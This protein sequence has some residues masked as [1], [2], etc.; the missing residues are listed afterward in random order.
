[1]GWGTHSW[2]RYLKYLKNPKQ[3]FKYEEKTFSPT[4]DPANLDPHHRTMLQN[5]KEVPNWWYGICLGLS[6]IAAGACIYLAES[7]LPWYLF[8]LAIVIAYLYVVF[9]G[10]LSGLLGFHVPIGSAIQLLGKVS[11]VCCTGSSLYFLLLLG[12]TTFGLLILLTE[13]LL[14]LKRWLA[15]PGEALEPDVLF[16]VCLYDERPSPLFG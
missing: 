3:I 11:F 7:T 15:Q 6:V 10:A 2:R 13:F 16:L 14:D 8:F 1:M 12:N 4:E 5:Y 9:F